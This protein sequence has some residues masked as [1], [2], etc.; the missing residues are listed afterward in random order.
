LEDNLHQPNSGGGEDNEDCF[1]REGCYKIGRE[2]S[3]E[4]DSSRKRKSKRSLYLDE[5]KTINQQLLWEQAKENKNQ[6]DL[7]LE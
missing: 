1:F 5:L 6:M 4:E 2:D 7:E 3:E